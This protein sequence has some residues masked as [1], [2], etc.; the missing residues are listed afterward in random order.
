MEDF[1]IDWANDLLS[2]LYNNEDNF[3]NADKTT[4]QRCYTEEEIK[5][6]IKVNVGLW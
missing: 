3:N 2:E 6:I 1:I 4:G 5:A